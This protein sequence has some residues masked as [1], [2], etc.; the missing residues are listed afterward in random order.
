M[1]TVRMTSDHEDK[2][3][4]NGNSTYASLRPLSPKAVRQVLSLTQ[5]PQ[6]K[7]LLRGRATDCLGL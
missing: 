5:L 2:M 1:G 6:Q 4:E 3:E 7:P